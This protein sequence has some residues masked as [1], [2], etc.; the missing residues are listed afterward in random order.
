MKRIAFTPDTGETALSEFAA[1][2]ENILTLNQL[3]SLIALLSDTVDPS[4]VVFPVL[5]AL[6]GVQNYAN[7][8]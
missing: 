6:R 8:M 4:T 3:K 1:K 5:M 2:T 7:G